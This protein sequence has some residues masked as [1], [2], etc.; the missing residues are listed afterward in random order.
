M[1]VFAGTNVFLFSIR[2][3]VPLR[4]FFKWLLEKWK[5]DLHLLLFTPLIILKLTAVV[6][7]LIGDYMEEIVDN[8]FDIVPEKYRFDLEGME[9]AQQ[10]YRDWKKEVNNG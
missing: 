4:F 9:K 3:K 2:N 7:I 1:E 5:Y 10:E 6:F 8:I